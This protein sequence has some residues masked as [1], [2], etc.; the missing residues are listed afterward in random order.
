MSQKKI[1]S[2]FCTL[3]VYNLFPMR[4]CSGGHYWFFLFFKNFQKKNFKKNVGHFLN[5]VIVQNMTDRIS[6][7]AIKHCRKYFQVLPAKRTW[8][9]LSGRQFL[10]HLWWQPL[11]MVHK[12]NS[13]RWTLVRVF[14]SKSFLVWAR[15]KFSALFVHY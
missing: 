13:G 14:C 10:G 1:V 15:K 8:V 2:T 12:T 5:Y 7:S 6:F 9:V 4:I 11:L 3:L